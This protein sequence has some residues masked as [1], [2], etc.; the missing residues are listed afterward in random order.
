MDHLMKESRLDVIRKTGVV[1]GGEADQL[2]CGVTQAGGC[3]DPVRP[4]DAHGIRGR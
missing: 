3:G 2:L 4:F 1:V